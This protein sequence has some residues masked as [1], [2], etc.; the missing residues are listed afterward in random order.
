[1]QNEVKNNDWRLGVDYL[2]WSFFDK[3]GSY[4]QFYFIQFIGI[5]NRIC[6][7]RFVIQK[8]QLRME[9]NKV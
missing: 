7:N 2:N 8:R 3:I 4:F 1:M 5:S 6:Q 9:R